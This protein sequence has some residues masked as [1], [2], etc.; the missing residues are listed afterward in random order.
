MGKLDGYVVLENYKEEV[1]LINEVQ[2]MVEWCEETDQ[3]DEI[4]EV[5]TVMAILW[6]IS[7]SNNTAKKIQ[8]LKS[9][10]KGYKLP[11]RNSNSESKKLVRRTIPRTTR[12]NYKK[13]NRDALGENNNM[14][15]DFL[16]K[17]KEEM[18]KSHENN[19]LVDLNSS[20]HPPQHG[21][22]EDSQAY[23]DQINKS[24]NDY[25]KKKQV[26]RPIKQKFSKKNSKTLR[27]FSYASRTNTLQRKRKTQNS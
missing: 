17:G 3:P 19:Q 9:G 12:F 10:N 22:L 8:K 13:N 21:N 23:Q 11:V 1:K 5:K 2:Q 18:L 27:K 26:S 20:C 16:K 14:M 15:T 6:P 4:E 25:L 7:F 24:V